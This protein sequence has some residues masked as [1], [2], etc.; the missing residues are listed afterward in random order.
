MDFAPASS[1][2]PKNLEEWMFPGLAST[3]VES[4]EARVAHSSHVLATHFNYGN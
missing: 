4:A 3:G 1:I 2:T